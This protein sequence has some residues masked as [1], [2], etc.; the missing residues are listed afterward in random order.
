L[1]PVLF[2]FRLRLLTVGTVEFIGLLV[3][4]AV[5]GGVV[6]GT[7]LWVDSTAN[8]RRLRRECRRSQRAA[9]RRLGGHAA[10][11]PMNAAVA[12]RSRA[13]TSATA[14]RTAARVRAGDE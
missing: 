14:S 11:P 3:L 13:A 12:A 5:L 10:S 2:R 9:R 7:S 4:V 8:L 6:V 1:F